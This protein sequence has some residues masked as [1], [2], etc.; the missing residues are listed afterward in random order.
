[1]EKKRICVLH[2]KVPFV[3][4]GAELLVKGLMDNLALGGF[5][6]E[7]IQLPYK[8]ETEN[9]LYD[10][11]LMW[12]LLD[13]N[14]SNGRKIDLVIGT[15]FPSYGVRHDN[16]VVWLVHQY[17]QAYDLFD[18]PVGLKNTPGGSKIQQKIKQF[19]NL[20]L[21]E[22]KSI[23]TISG[24]VS[25]RLLSNNNLPSKPLYSPPSLVGRYFCG[26]YQDYLLSVGRLD[27]LKRNDLLIAALPFCPKNI[28]AK[29]AGRGPEMQA[30]QQLAEELGVSDRVDFLGFVADKDLLEL[31]A[32]AMAVFYAPVDEDYGY[33]TL[34][35][36]LSK[37]PVITCDD[38]GGVL[39]FVR[40]DENGL[41]S[42]SDARKIAAGIT[43]IAS[44]KNMC[45]S[46]GSAG[47]ESVKDISWKNVVDTLTASI[48]Q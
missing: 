36:F 4:G 23:Y 24:N 6:T 41:V 48:Q 30:L 7:L 43:R 25:S 31:Y 28:R 29:I 27:P 35:A 11:L 9:D 47:F 20:T 22:A 1:M 42:S 33:I 16:K 38:S 13:L 14:E 8:W 39:E 26:E 3:Y 17:R 45:R 37:K 34:E 46:F 18:S 2:A 12:R 44:D 19:D 10:N 32:N 21:N 40:S 5:E 15:K